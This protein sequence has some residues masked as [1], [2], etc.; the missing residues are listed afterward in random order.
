LA[1]LPALTLVG[2][3]GD[4]L[5]VPVYRRGSEF[6]NARENRLPVITWLLD[7]SRL[8]TGLGWVIALCGVLDLGFVWSTIGLHP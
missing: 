7:R 8:A 2:L 1:L 4:F 6:E 3:L 5:A